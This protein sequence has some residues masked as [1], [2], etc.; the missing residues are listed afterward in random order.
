M[1]CIHFLLATSTH[2]E[3]ISAL[4]CCRCVRL[5]VSLSYVD[6]IGNAQ[7]TSRTFSKLNLERFKGLGCL[8][9]SRNLIPDLNPSEFT[10]L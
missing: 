5:F 4:M 7:N 1:C 9:W 6:S 10:R 3:S 2:G 8:T